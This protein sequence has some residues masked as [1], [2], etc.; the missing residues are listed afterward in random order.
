M[1][2]V[3]YDW[4][5]HESIEYLDGAEFASKWQCVGFEWR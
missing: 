3:G 5:V 4:G 2:L 1:A